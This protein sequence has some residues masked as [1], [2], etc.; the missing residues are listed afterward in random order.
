[1]DPLAIFDG[2]VGN[3]VQRAVATGSLALLIVQFVVKAKVPDRGLYPIIA[4]VLALA[5]N[6]VAELRVAPQDWVLA[7]LYGMLGGVVAA[8]MWEQGKKV[9]VVIGVVKSALSGR[10]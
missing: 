10:G 1:M 4:F 9:P 7:V 2:I 6:L 3:P 5:L 8:G